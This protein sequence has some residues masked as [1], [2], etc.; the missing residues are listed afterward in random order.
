MTALIKRAVVGM[1]TSESTGNGSGNGNRVDHL[2]LKR[3][4]NLLGVGEVQTRKLLRLTSG[5]FH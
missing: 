1:E 5:T 2:E 4:G 3:A